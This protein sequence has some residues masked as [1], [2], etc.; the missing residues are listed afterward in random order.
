[1]CFDLLSARQDLNPADFFF[2]HRVFLHVFVCPQFC[3]AAYDV[4][5]RLNW[6]FGSFCLPLFLGAMYFFAILVVNGFP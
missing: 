4:A 5:T 2:L 6:E 3:A 1:M